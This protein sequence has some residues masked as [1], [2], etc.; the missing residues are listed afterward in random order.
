MTAMLAGSSGMRMHARVPCGVRCARSSVPRWV[1]AISFAIAS[2]GRC[3]TGFGREERLDR[4][5]G[6]LRRD[7]L[8]LVGDD[9]R[10]LGGIGGDVDAHGAARR[11]GVARVEQQIDERVLEQQRLAADLGQPAGDVRAR[12]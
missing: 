7:A 9:E 6:V 10:D 4:A 12:A 8:A 11:R 1:F 3:P 2:R 5:R